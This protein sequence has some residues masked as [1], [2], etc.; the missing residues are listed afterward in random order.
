VKHNSGK[1]TV[2]MK[3][4]PRRTARLDSH[5]QIRRARRE[6]ANLLTAL[7]I[8]SKAYWGY[9]AA[10]M[11]ACV[12][13]LTI[14]PDR[15]AAEQFF[16]LEMDGR[17]VGFAGLRVQIPEAELTNLFVEPTAIGW[18]YGKRLW[19]HV[20]D[21]ARSIGAARMRIESDPFAEAFYRAMGAQRIGETPSD[22]IPRMIP[23]LTFNL[24]S[25]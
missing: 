5:L 20:I 24:L 3:P 17:V 25:M 11:Q 22:A 15:I 7:A 10:F 2:A 16:V 8:R 4:P 12:P 18:G 9:D 21:A 1:A 13:A 19:Q 6:D 23:L 14:S